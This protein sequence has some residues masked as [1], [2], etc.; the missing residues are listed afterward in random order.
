MRRLA[1]D[2]IANR[3]GFPI[4]MRGNEYLWQGEVKQRKAGFRSP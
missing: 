2:S 4:P 3:A 1:S